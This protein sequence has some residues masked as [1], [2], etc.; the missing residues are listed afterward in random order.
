MYMV[1]PTRVSENMPL[2][3]LLNEF[4]KGHSHMAVVVGE[5]GSQIEQPSTE[6]PTD[7]KHQLYAMV[8][9]VYTVH[10]SY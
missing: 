7:G 6:N 9:H 4:Q 3:V 10:S 2:Y 1:L 5:H 8:C